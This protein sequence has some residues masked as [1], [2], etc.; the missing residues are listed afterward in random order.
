MGEEANAAHFD[1]EVDDVFA[2]IAGRYDRLCDIFS[3]G[4]HRYW[5]SAMA[6]EICSN[7][8]GCVLDV[9]SGT[10][11]IP[12]RILQRSS[13]LPN[14]RPFHR[15]IVSDKCPAMLSIARDRLGDTQLIDYRTLDAHALLEIPSSSIDTYCTSFVMKICDRQRVLSEAFRVLKPGG[16]FFCLE[17]SRLKFEM[18][19]RAYLR[20]MEWCLPLIGRLETRGD[21][22]AYE[23]FLK[24]IRDF[25]KQQSFVRELEKAGFESVR[26]RNLSFGIVALHWCKKPS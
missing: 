23:Y 13:K 26:Y 3:L 9:G 1:P 14:S 24:G 22:S 10:G 19:H 4:I 11:D 18:L 5:K 20:Y 25:P 17:A 2:R 8:Q 7:G 21:P 16:W 12:L 15:L 6:K